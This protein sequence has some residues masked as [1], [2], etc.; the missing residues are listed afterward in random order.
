MFLLIEIGLDW[1]VQTCGFNHN[2]VADNSLCES[3]SDQGFSLD[4]CHMAP[5]HFKISPT[6]N[7]AAFPFDLI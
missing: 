7:S 5:E 6:L 1:I 3:I 2:V 4:A